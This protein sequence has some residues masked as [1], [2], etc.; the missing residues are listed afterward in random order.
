MP[1]AARPCHPSGRYTDEEIERAAEECRRQWGL[2]FGP[3]SNVLA[4]LEGKGIA[5]CRYDI[6]NERIDAFSFWCG[7]R[8]FIF[9]ASEKESGVRIRFDL[10]HELGHLV[11]HRW[12]DA[13]EILN[14]KTL[15][16]IEAEADRFAGAFLLPRQSFPNEVYTPRLDAFLDLKRRW[17]I[18]VQAMVYRCRDLGVI[19][20]V[21]FTNLYKQISFR[22]WRTREPLDHPEE[23]RLESPR[24]LNKAAHLVLNSGKKNPDEIR[25][26][27]SM[28]PKIIEKF[29]NLPEGRLSPCP[30]KDFTPTL[31]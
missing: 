5:A 2:G 16:M 24:L 1:F 12:I 6:E 29:L 10:A 15:K 18:S 3:I 20:E 21:Q 8:P 27:L 19:D 26:D 31:K 23:I 25:S 4:L 14:P 7:D 9:M 30:P 22:R 28:S 17:L 11:M 13:D